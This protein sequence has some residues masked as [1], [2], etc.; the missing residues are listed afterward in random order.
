MFSQAFGD[1]LK[2]KKGMVA[3]LI[4]GVI[5]LS[6][7]FTFV[8]AFEYRCSSSLYV[9]QNQQGLLSKDAYAAAKS[10]EK[11]AKNMS[12]MIYTSTFMERVFESNYGVERNI[13]SSDEIKK[14]KE[15]NKKIET[16]VVP[17]TG[18]LEIKV[19][20]KDK[21]MAERVTQAIIYILVT[22]GKDFHGGGDDI[23]IRIAD[24]PIVSKYPARP[25][26]VINLTAAL[27][28]GILASFTIVFLSTPESNASLFV[29]EKNGRILDYEEPFE[30]Q[31]TP[32]HNSISE[33]NRKLDFLSKKDTSNYQ[34]FKDIKASFSNEFNLLKEELY[35]IVAQQ[36]NS[37]ADNLSVVKSEMTRS[38]NVLKEDLRVIVN[39][40]N[41]MITKDSIQDLIDKQNQNKAELDVIVSTIK[42]LATKDGLRQ[43]LE[44]QKQSIDNLDSP[45]LNLE[46]IATKDGIEYIRNQQVKN[47]EN[48]NAIISSLEN[49]ATKDNIR[50]VIEKQ[51]Q[52]IDSLDN[53]VLNLEEIATKDSVKHI[54]DQQN[55]NTENINSII[56]SLENIATK[57]N[58][59]LVIEKQKQNSISKEIIEKMIN[60]IK[61][62]LNK[63]ID[64]TNVSET[65]KNIGSKLEVLISKN[66]NANQ[67]VEWKGVL[68]KIY[69]LISKESENNEKIATLDKTEGRLNRISEQ[70]SDI[71]SREVV[72]KVEFTR[73]IEKQNELLNNRNDNS[74]KYK[75]EAKQIRQ[76]LNDLQARVDNCVTNEKVEGLVAK[77]DQ[78][79]SKNDLRRLIQGDNSS[80]ESLQEKVQ[81]TATSDDEASF[82]PKIN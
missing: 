55:I 53:S 12:R 15:W 79:L 30:K 58:I 29:G 24:A 40:L 76:N 51:K 31:I 75:Q 3:L 20:D 38:V 57:D 49:T 77:Q 54:H 44:Q 11:L 1:N 73:F 4:L 32:I 67:G 64:N 60:E 72:T 18:I 68:E 70:L 28:L 8:Q 41:D 45:I 80:Q 2:N 59:R 71:A 26:I 9:I 42:N 37:V 23:N 63:P 10:A 65:L 62:I 22:D 27:I 14:R 34:G 7:I 43:V 33:A 25:N 35:D 36:K 13:L 66:N 61:E 50:L 5:I 82:N 6:L 81:V 21:A 17:E 39:G 52:S 19:Y 47:A 46:N 48:I 74:E 78:Y 56:S 69:Q 16:Y